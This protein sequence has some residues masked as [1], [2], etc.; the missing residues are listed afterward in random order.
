MFLWKIVARRKFPAY[1]NVLSF[2]IRQIVAVWCCL[3]LLGGSYGVLQT[4]A[5]SRMIVTNTANDGLIEGIQKTFDGEHP[6][7]MCCQI[8]QAK[9]RDSAPDPI[10]DL[11][12]KDAAVKYFTSSQSV[13]DHRLT[14]AE[15]VTKTPLPPAIQ[16][17]LGAEPPVLPPPRAVA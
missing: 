5:W 11:L 15:I 7:E 12:Q 3:Q 14:T 1:P 6:C 10:R 13:V 16:R 8:K 2:R 9:Q 4:I 17:G